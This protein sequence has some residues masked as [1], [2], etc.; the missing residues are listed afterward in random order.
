MPLGNY[1]SQF[2]ANVYLNEFD[3]FV[4]H[5]LKARYYMRYVDDFVILH[6]SR[7]VLELHKE[8]II[9]YL[10]CLK[11]ELHS[12]KSNIIPL[13]NG[14]TFLGYRIFYYYKLLRKKNIK[15]FN[16]KF[17]KILKSYENKELTKEQIIEQLQGWF[18]YAQWANTYKFRE[19]INKRIK[20]ITTNV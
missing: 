17:E 2:F 10:E 14:V 5:I 16:R 13:R 18:G 11:L 3:Y 7:K 1:T 15:T 9:K 8:R 19:E 6:K 20:E 4:K 12:D